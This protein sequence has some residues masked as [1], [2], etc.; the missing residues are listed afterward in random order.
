MVNNDQV[1]FAEDDSD[2][3][4]DESIDY[5]WEDVE[6]SQLSHYDQNLYDHFE[7]HYRGFKITRT[8]QGDYIIYKIGRKHNHWLLDTEGNAYERKYNA[9]KYQYLFINKKGVMEEIKNE[10]D[11]LYQS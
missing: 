4:G 11:S 10:I 3:W 1:C 7:M 5:Y 2:M 9:P 6:L 8:W